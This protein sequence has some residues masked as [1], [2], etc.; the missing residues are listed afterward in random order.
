MTAL[1]S[2]LVTLADVAK[3]KDKVIGGV[4]EVLVINN[5]ILLDLP[6]MEMNEGTIHK[7]EIRSGLPSVY[8][9]KANQAIPASKSTTE[10]RTFTATHFES[11]SSMD[12][13]VARRG[14][15]DRVA[16]NRWNQAQGHLQAHSNE[17]GSLLIYGSPS[18][19]NLKTAG[20][21]DIYST[22]DTSVE[23]YK[24]IVD[25]GG[26][27]SDNTSIFKIHWGPQSVF[28][29]YP[30]G[31]KAGISRED[32]S[33]NHKLVQIQ[34]LDE[35]GNTG[36]FWGYEEDFMTDHG[37]VVKDYRQAARIANID[38][39]NL[40]SGSGAADLINLMIDANFKIHNRKIG[41]G[42]W[43]CNSTIHA[44]L[45]KQARTAV[46]AGGGLTYDNV[47]GKPVLFFMGEPIRMVD[48][49]L[50]TEEAVTT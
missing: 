20:L 39:S 3:S 14:G 19:S 48:A 45:Y 34:G 7:E 4:A 46:G 10:E 17:L 21:T 49:I 30:K 27:G 28:G 31:T 16:Y 13:D 38:V 23:T 9:R 15:M 8:Y 36:T 2:T 26:T 32:M 40:I 6:Y 1:G 12:K 29:I 50:D 47:D 41:N 24:Q 43:Y 33:P 25:G 44:H 5:E 37:L 22:L 18:S 35:N 11:K 42:V